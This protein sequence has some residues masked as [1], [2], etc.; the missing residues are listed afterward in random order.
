MV[1]TPLPL[2]TS[3]EAPIPLIFDDDGSPD[4]VIAL[5]FFL[6]NSQYSVEAVTI[7]PG[8]AHPELFAHQMTRL[9]ASVGRSDIPVGVGRESPLEGDNSFPEP[10]RQASDAFWDISLPEENPPSNTLSAAELIVD[11]LHGSTQPMAIFVSGSHTNLAEALRLDP[12]IREHI[13]EIY[14]MGGSIYGQGNIESDWPAIRNRAAEWNIWVDPT[15]ASEVFASGLP[16]HI[17][18]LDGT[19]QVT[20]TQSDGQSWAS[21]GTPEG[22]L[23]NDLLSWMLTSWSTDRA[24][25]W[26]LAAAVAMT[27]QRLCPE[28]P[29]ALDI[30]VEPGPEQGR[31][32]AKDAPPNAQ[33]CVEPDA[34]QI[35]ARAASIFAR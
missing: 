6:R 34:D 11:T 24:F 33:V 17:M 14:M 3:G 9:L 29:L 16:L 30:N 13:R 26:D 31:T 23:A 32:I 27:D 8:E 19:N 20:W 21:S 5:L 28:I 2:P 1:I 22:L 15:A 12:S 25:I 7:S 18:P 4:G 10:W 35:R